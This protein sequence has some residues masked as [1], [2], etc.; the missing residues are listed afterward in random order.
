M[1]LLQNIDGTK[2]NAKINLEL[3]LKNSEKEAKVRENEFSQVGESDKS[4]VMEQSVFQRIREYDK[5]Q[6]KNSEK[7]ETV[8]SSSDY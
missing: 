8:N 7:K 5:K 2:I 1:M 6:W 4:D 3:S